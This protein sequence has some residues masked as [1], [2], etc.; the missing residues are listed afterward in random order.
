MNNASSQ[1]GNTIQPN[2]AITTERRSE[3]LAEYNAL[4]GEILNRFGERH[5]ILTFSIAILGAILTLSKDATG[6]VLLAYPI[7][8][9]FLAIGWS[10]ADYRI[11]EIAKYIRDEIEPQVPGIQWERTLSE[12]RRT[13]SIKRHFRPAELSAA[14]IFVGTEILSLGL[15]Y[16]KLTMNTQ[17][18]VLLLL[19]VV[20]IV[21][22]YLVIQRRRMWH[23]KVT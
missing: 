19:D 11:A 10:H 4:R 14:G 23:S 7:L 15:A 21:V 6:V 18:T 13:K 1:E 16:P 3:I 9:T 22:T 17:E 5:Q 8:S 20:G 2:I 12:K